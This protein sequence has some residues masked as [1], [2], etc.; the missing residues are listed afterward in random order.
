MHIYHEQGRMPL[1]SQ[2]GAILRGFAFLQN[3]RSRRKVSKLRFARLAATG[4]LQFNS[5]RCHVWLL[6]GEAVPLVV[7]DSPPANWPPAL[8]SENQLSDG[9]LWAASGRQTAYSPPQFVVEFCRPHIYACVFVV[10]NNN[11][12]KPNKIKHACI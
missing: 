6:N 12:A 1:E 3:E 10:C 11:S 2:E 4:I 8:R 9:G 5:E 7:V